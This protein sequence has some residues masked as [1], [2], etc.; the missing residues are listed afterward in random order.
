MA[1]VNQTNIATVTKATLGKFWETGVER[2]IM[3]FS[4]RIDTILI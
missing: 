4:A 1:I 2:I 3:G